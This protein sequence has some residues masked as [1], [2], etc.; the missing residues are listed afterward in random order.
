MSIHFSKGIS[1]REILMIYITGLLA[2]TFWPEK[3]ASTT[4]VNISKNIEIRIDESSPVLAAEKD[5]L[6]YQES[7]NIISQARLMNLNQQIRK[8]PAIQAV[9]LADYS[10]D[11]REIQ[12]PNRVRLVGPLQLNQGLALTGDNR[13]EVVHEWQGQIFERGEVNV[14]LGTY[15]IEIAKMEGTLCAKL[16]GDR[17]E[18]MGKGCISLD[19]Y[20]KLN[21]SLASGPLL[22]VSKYQDVAVMAES[23]RSV[24]VAAHALPE[25]ETAK[26]KPS[27]SH[28]I[29][30][31][32]HSDQANPP[33]IENAVVENS[34][35][36]SE[37][38]TSFIIT[39]IK[40]A[41]Q[42][43]ARV[44]SGGRTSRRGVPLMPDSATKALNDIAR[45]AGYTDSDVMTRGFVLGRVNKEGRTIAGVDVQ[46]EGRPDLK[47]LYF[48]ELYIPDPNQ[49]TTA[50]HGIYT[51]IN[52]PDGEYALR[53]EMANKFVGFQNASVRSGTMALA[54]IDSTFRKREVQLAT[55]D[56]STK[57]SQPAVLTL[58]AYQEDVI[59][60]SGHAD[61]LLSEVEDNSFVFAHPVNR[62]YLTTQYLLEPGENLYSFPMIHKNW[63]ENILA[64]AKLNR[65]IQGRIAMG[66]GPDEPFRAYAVGSESARVIYFDSHA[67][68][69]EGDFGPAGGGFIILDPEQEISEFAIQRSTQKALKVVYMPTQP[70]VVSILT[71]PGTFS[72][73][74]SPVS[75]HKN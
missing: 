7:T 5:L 70:G 46:I 10:R 69:V 25:I 44:V 9:Q 18:I 42:T 22:N 61:V 65:S 11:L 3:V 2:V 6:S 58:Q 52:V 34:V 56:V 60:D 51:F 75:G 27:I 14:D 50:S 68:V 67:Q 53:A 66:F 16:T 40:A 74:D 62:D 4:F 1:V 8:A 72:H 71:V 35:D 63:M 29:Y 28:K 21:R 15:S 39:Q 12:N 26:I 13:I 48:N 17:Y 54:D 41:G 36:N 57:I 49:K 32:Y 64:Q 73:S 47:P 38:E 20:R 55:Y 37:D 23:L 31:Y 59:L 30:N 33:S 24:E 19:Q 45:N 43:P